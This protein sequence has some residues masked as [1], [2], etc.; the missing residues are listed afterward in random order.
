MWERATSPEAADFRSRRDYLPPEEP[1]YASGQV[2]DSIHDEWKIHIAPS[3]AVLGVE[4]AAREYNQTGHRLDKTV[5][6]ARAAGASW[7]SIPCS[8]AKLL[9]GRH[10]STI[11][12]Y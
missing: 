5:A 2:E 4:A 9:E 3:E 7:A 6:A 12:K 8:F 11:N 10:R 1:A